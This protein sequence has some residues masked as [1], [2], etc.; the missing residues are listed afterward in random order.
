MLLLQE[1]KGVKK[2]YY[3]VDEL[4]LW[5]MLVYPLSDLIPGPSPNPPA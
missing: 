5:V 4:S 2:I 3:H 1:E